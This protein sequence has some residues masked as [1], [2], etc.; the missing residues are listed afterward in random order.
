MLS[1]FKP[2]LRIQEE[3][4][5]VLT[6]GNLN[7]ILNYKRLRGCHSLIGEDFEEIHLSRHLTKEDR[8]VESGCRVMAYWKLMSSYDFC[9]RL[10]NCQ[11]LFTFCNS[12]KHHCTV[13]KYL[14]CRAMNTLGKLAR[15]NIG[16][17]RNF[18][19]VENCINNL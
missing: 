18:V 5:S 14:D 7:V 11:L 10:V 16:L 3:V 9:F 17:S 15:V 4:L 1:D 19:R 6:C 12:H 13:G 2:P 8:K